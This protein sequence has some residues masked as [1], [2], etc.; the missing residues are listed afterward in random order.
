MLPLIDYCNITLLAAS[1]LYIDKLQKLLNNAV[2]FIF[3]LT[4]KKYRCSITPYLKQ[5]HILPVLLRIKYKVALTVY[6]CF[7][8]LAP[9][10]LQDLIKP[11]FTF[12]H[13]RSSND[14]YSLQSVV[15]KSKYGESTFEY[16]APRVWNALPIN[17][18]HSPSLD[19]FK[20]RLKSHY[21]IEY[22]GVELLHC[23]IHSIIEVLML[24]MSIRNQSC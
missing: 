14:V 11:K 22:F 19:C 20:K 18:K 1:K 7:H 15:P 3:N 9:S 17:V 4:G 16:A 23:I 24:F 10:Y 13:L 8:D 6:K 21:F 12:S 2:R 5:L